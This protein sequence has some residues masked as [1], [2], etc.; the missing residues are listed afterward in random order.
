MASNT[1]SNQIS[2]RL[3]AIQNCIAWIEESF[4]D[5]QP[6]YYRDIIGFEASCLMAN[7]NE[8][9]D[10][11]DSDGE[12]TMIGVFAKRDILVNETKVLMT[13][14]R[15]AVLSCSKSSLRNENVPAVQSLLKNTMK[16]Y[17][18]FID[19]AFERSGVKDHDFYR[20][21]YGRMLADSEVRLT[22][23]L[24][25]MLCFMDGD[26]NNN[27]PT[28]T[29][30]TDMNIGSDLKD[31][32]ERL[33]EKWTPYLNTWPR[34]F[35][36]LPPFWSKA[37]L[38]NIR[39]TSFSRYIARLQKELVENWENVVGPFLAETGIYK[40]TDVD[41]KDMSTSTS[42]STSEESRMRRLPMFYQLAVGAVQSR[43]HG[44]L[45]SQEGERD[46]LGRIDGGSMDA[47]L[48]P[49]LDL[50]NGERA[51]EHVNVELEGNPDSNRL[52]LR[53]VR[54]IKAGEELIIS[55]AD[56]I[57][58][59]YLQR[60]GFLP[61]RE[62]L[63]DPNNGWLTLSLPS[64]LVPDSEDRLRWEKL[65]EQGFAKENISSQTHGAGPFALLYDNGQM[66]RYRKSPIGVACPP[67][68]DKLYTCATILLYNEKAL[69]DIPQEP[70]LANYDPG[71][72]MV[73]M[74]DYWLSQL[75]TPSNEHDFNLIESQSGNL[76]MGT[77]MRMLEREILV[78]WRHAVCIRHGCY[79]YDGEFEETNV[80]H[81]PP[82]TS[83][84]CY[85]CKATFY[86]K[87]CTRCKVVYYCGVKCQKEHWRQGHKE[88]C[89]KD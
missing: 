6:I 46:L 23:F 88:V 18:A 29:D 27:N 50:V 5:N 14:P 72:M 78:K 61:L 24:T 32:L 64:H 31:E 37:E 86:V 77:Y 75:A 43:T 56:A 26:N 40:H 66:R 65:K 81:V 30:E 62:G 33:T 80:I 49:L 36:S 34:D 55:Y 71:K 15:P 41:Q 85:I 82:M 28:R 1:T 20:F 4:N 7:Q 60:F 39:G 16:R 2:M 53:V 73:Q 3:N 70:F 9:P 67:Q 57:P 76:R 87:K 52:E 54:D 83:K 19:D 74:I 79:D 21:S 12:N 45:E 25:L 51:E 63:P 44:S 69:H 84:C 68:L 42:T 59:S 47:V 11:H 22:F 17:D 48:H 38:E 89:G 8:D 10:Q 58:M 13:L 35:N